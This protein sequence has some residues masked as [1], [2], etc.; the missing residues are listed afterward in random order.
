MLTVSDIVPISP[1]VRVFHRIDRYLLYIYRIREIL[2]DVLGD[3][4]TCLASKSM[5]RSA[6]YTINA[7]ERAY[8][9]PTGAANR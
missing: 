6:S 9:D 7:I 4:Q 1:T 5:Q 3:R 8:Q 2:R